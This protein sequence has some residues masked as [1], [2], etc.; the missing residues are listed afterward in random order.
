MDSCPGNVGGKSCH[1]GKLS[2]AYFVFWATSVFTGLFWSFVA[3]RRSFVIV[4]L[5]IIL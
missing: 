2:V 5:L 1:R 4:L 3:F